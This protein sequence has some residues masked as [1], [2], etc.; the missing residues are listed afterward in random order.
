MKVLLYFEGQN[1]I[2]KSGIGRALKHQIK[3][4]ESAG[5]S[6]TLNPEDDFDILHINTYF[7]NSEFIIKKC[8]K[9][10]IP[11]I[12]H[13]HSTEEDFK[14][15]FVFAN[16]ISPL[17][18]RYLVNL[19]SKADEIITPT[20]YAKNILKSYNINLPIHPISNGIDLQR[21][22]YDEEK[23]KHFINISIYQVVIRLLSV[24]VCCLSEKDLLIL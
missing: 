21:Y 3:A 1:A 22:Q 8:R 7:L 6:Y 13:A 9:N 23:L 19:Y 14:N 5:I 10:N 4:L 17:Y 20:I 2:K 18:K 15:S 24:W 16:Q 11:I 12:Y